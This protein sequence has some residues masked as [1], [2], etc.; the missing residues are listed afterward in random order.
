MKKLDLYTT[1]DPKVWSRE[2]NV[3]SQYIQSGSRG[4]VKYLAPYV[5]RVG[6]SNSRI[7][8]VKNRTVTFKY[9][10]QRSDRWKTMSLDVME[11]IRRFLQ[12]VLPGG[13]MKIR[14]Y[15]FMGSGCKITTEELTA[16][17]VKAYEFKIII[18]EYTL[19]AERPSMK[20]E[21][22]GG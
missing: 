11:F 17:I 13:F 20:C 2:W 10:K 8:S 5:F 6:I 7:V 18:P 14:Y 4:A 9:K 1:V 19:P 15:G 16:K 21:K 12:H 3:N 22:C